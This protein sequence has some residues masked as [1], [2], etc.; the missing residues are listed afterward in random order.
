MGSGET[1]PTIQQSADAVTGQ[2]ASNHLMQQISVGFSESDPAS[3]QALESITVLSASNSPALSVSVGFSETDPAIN[4]NRSI[5]ELRSQHLVDCLGG[6]SKGEVFVT[7]K[8]SS[9]TETGIQ[10]EIDVGLRRYNL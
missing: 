9:L 6:N 3:H 10:H 8:F 4:L 1:D 7:P 5:G 2:Q